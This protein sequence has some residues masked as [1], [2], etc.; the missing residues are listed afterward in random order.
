M[1]QTWF[2]LA[3]SFI[4][5]AA[6]YD[7]YF[8]YAYRSVV[9][10]WELN[11]LARWGVQAMGLPAVLGFK[12]I[13]LSFAIAVAL[14]CRRGNL[15]LEVYLTGAIATAY[16]ALSMIYVIGHLAYEFERHRFAAW[17]RPAPQISRYSVARQIWIHLERP[18]VNPTGE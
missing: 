16:F 1:R 9:D 8:A 6:T 4:F 13:G 11:P 10:D 15:R 14:Y 12:A 17:Q 18:G 5:L 3:W 7:C 2:N